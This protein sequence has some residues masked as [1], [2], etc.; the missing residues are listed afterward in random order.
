LLVLGIEPR[1]LYMLD[2]CSVTDPQFSE[3]RL[4]FGGFVLLGFCCYDGSVVVDVVCFYEIVSLC[5]LA[6]LE[7]W[8]SCN[9]PL[10]T[11]ITDM[12]HLTQQKKKKG[13]FNH[14]QGL[15]PT[16]Q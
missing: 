6:C 2:K 14:S 1:S 8:S 15:C 5:N 16:S 12:C 3:C 10:R 11:G 4:A 7:F 13:A 9:S